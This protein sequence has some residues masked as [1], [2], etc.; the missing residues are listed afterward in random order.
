MICDKDQVSSASIV[1]IIVI[2]FNNYHKS[3]PDVFLL[4]AL[5]V[6]A[7]KIHVAYEH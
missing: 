5:F 1:S 4:L 7:A 3:F 2:C 6:A